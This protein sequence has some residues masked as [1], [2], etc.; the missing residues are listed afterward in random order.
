M[1]HWESGKGEGA[2]HGL[3]VSDIAAVHAKLGEVAAKWSV[4]PCAVRHGCAT[5]PQAPIA[6]LTQ[7]DGQ[8]GCGD[9]AGRNMPAD[10]HA[11]AER[12]TMGGTSVQA[13]ERV[14]RATGRSST[15]TA[16]PGLVLAH[17]LLCVRRRHR[18]H[19][20]TA[21][22]VHSHTHTHAHTHTQGCRTPHRTPH[23]ALRKPRRAAFVVCGNNQQTKVAN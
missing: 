18:A 10:A 5:N 17:S 22:D 13:F 12:E 7:F 21:T 3:T 2:R 20:A 19:T 16:R 6:T 8:P 1:L 15:V 4:C 9:P 11:C 23:P 14:H